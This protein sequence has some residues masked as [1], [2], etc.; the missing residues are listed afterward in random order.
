MRAAPKVPECHDQA[1][2]TCSDL[3]LEARVIELLGD[4]LARVE[5]GGETET[6][7]IALVEARPGDIILVHAREAIA[8]L[9]A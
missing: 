6:I 8:K 3:A 4:D 5:V 7:S 1:C 2:V 9:T